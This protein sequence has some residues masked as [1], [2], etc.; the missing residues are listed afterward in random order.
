MCVNILWQKK[1][2]PFNSPLIKGGC[3]LAALRCVAAGGQGDHRTLNVI[4]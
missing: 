4:K 1:D 2:P 3:R